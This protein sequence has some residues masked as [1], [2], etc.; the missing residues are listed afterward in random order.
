[1]DKYSKLI[2][3]TNGKMGLA[4]CQNWINQSRLAALTKLAQKYNI[5]VDEVSDEQFNIHKKTLDSF[6]LNKPEGLSEEE[7]KNAE[8]I[9]TKSVQIAGL[10]SL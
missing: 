10:I 9:I 8:Y 4:I 3:E 1:M 2:E 7:K 5:P 6:L